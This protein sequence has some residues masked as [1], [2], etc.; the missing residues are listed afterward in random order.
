MT[1]QVAAKYGDRNRGAGY[2]FLEHRTFS[3]EA[4][5]LAKSLGQRVILLDGQRIT[6]LMIE[7][8]VGI[9]THH[10]VD[11]KNS[12]RIF[13]ARRNVRLWFTS[14]MCAPREDRCGMGLSS[15]MPLPSCAQNQTGAKVRSLWWLRW[16]C[17]N[18][19]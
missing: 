19:C 3:R 2:E 13:S 6:D 14:C 1:L 10:T 18:S 8:N 17:G 12:T 9:R 5:E 16:Q 11:F 15:V 7:R 4:A